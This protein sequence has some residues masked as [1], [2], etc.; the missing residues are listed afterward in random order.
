[1]LWWEWSWSPT[2]PPGAETRKHGAGGS[3]LWA[4]LGLL[5]E[6]ESPIR[7]DFGGGVT[8]PVVVKLTTGPLT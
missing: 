3:Q 5:D 4:R 1:M 8:R 2:P 6:M 7:D